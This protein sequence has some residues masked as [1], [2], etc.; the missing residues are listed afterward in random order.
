MDTGRGEFIQGESI[1]DLGNML[2]GD[3][4]DKM[5]RDIGV[6]TVGHTV[7]IKGSK[8]EIKE[9][10]RTGMRLKLL[11]SEDAKGK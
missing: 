10:D 11:P 2:S 8:F 5:N 6:F 1:T 3:L 9:I 7:W 4:K